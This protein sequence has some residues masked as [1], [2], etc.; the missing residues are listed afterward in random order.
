MSNTDPNKNPESILE[1]ALSTVIFCTELRLFSKIYSIKATVLICWIHRYKDSICSKLR[2]YLGNYV[3][4]E[5]LMKLTAKNLYSL[6][7]L[8]LIVK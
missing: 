7:C 2:I 8:T 3:K 6:L 4:Q 1:R 5:I